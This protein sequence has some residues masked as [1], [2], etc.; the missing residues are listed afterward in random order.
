PMSNVTDTNRTTTTP[1]DETRP[2][3]H[4]SDVERSQ[5]TPPDVRVS[6][7]GANPNAPPADEV[8]AAT[9]QNQD[10]ADRTV[11]DLVAAGVKRENVV[12]FADREDKRN[13]MKR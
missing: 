3:M 4:P 12:V 5:H 7:P 6:V 2:V 11:A 10:E 9:Y 8:V 1:T 13:F